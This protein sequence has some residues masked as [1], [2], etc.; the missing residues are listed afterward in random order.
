MDEAK[1]PS[2]TVMRAFFARFGGRPRP[3]QTETFQSIQDD[4]DLLVTAPTS[5]GK[6]EAVFVPLAIRLLARGSDGKGKLGALVISPTRAL[7]TDL[8]KR[9][10][11]IF[12]SLGL[13]LDVS[14]GDKNTCSATHPSD[15]LIRTPEGLDGLLCRHPEQLNYLLDVAIDELH[16]FVEDARGTQL[17]GL[18][19]RL[20]SRVP[21]HRRLGISAT[22]P[23]PMLPINMG[24][25]RGNTITISSPD[26]GKIEFIQHPWLGPGPTSADHFLSKLREI[27]CKKAIAFVNSRKRAEEM[28]VLLNRGFL[29]GRCFVHHGSTSTALRRETEECLRTFQVAL[30]VATTTLEVGIDVGDLDTTIL[31]DLPRDLNALLQRAGRAGRRN[32]KRRVLYVTG[33]F[34]RAT[35]FA[36]MIAQAQRPRPTATG[37]ARPFLSGCLQQAISLVASKGA[38]S[39]MGLVHFLE[40]AFRLP[41]TQAWQILESLVETGLLAKNDTSFVLTHNSQAM[42]EN[43]SIHITFSANAGTPIYDAVSHRRIG[44]ALVGNTGKILLGG[45]ARELTGMDPTTGRVLAKQSDG[46][47]ASFPRQAQSTFDQVATQCYPKMGG[48]VRLNP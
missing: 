11:P 20:E 2:I 8:H 45:R 3:I 35:D 48:R 30:V 23:D 27:Q 37:D 24:L 42:L 33:L 1:A 13:R 38:E 44:Q 18:L 7:A 16:K 5:S 39:G 9:M 29:K 26:D 21:G 10:E 12:Q 40:G 28:A 46:G 43:R 36:P 19:H 31:L 41:Q 14:T 25:L 22:L 17:I 6:T 34:D 47:A 32:G 4:R 15:A